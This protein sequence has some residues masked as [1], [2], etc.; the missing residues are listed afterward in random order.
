[1]KIGILTHHYV[2]NF[3]ATLQATA[4][5][6]TIKK[7]NPDAKVE[8][9]NYT[10]KKHKFKNVIRFFR[11]RYDRDTPKSY[12][13]KLKLLNSH[14]KDEKKL[15]RSKKMKSAED[16]NS[17]NYDL[18]IIGSDEVWNF[19][20]IAYS[21]IKFGYGLKKTKVI[22]YAASVGDSSIED[23][24]PK[25]V[26]VGINSLNSISV[27]DKKSLELCF[28]TGHMATKVL[29]PVFIYEFPQINLSENNFDK[30]KKD[31][32]LIYD[33]RITND[34]INEIKK[35]AKKKDLDIIGA[36]EHRKWYSYD[37][38]NVTA[39]EWASL[40]KKAAF[41]ITGTFHGAS[42][43]IK[44]R[45][46]FIVYA[47][48]NNRI[49]KVSSLLQDLNQ[50]ERIITPNS[51]F[52]KLQKLLNTPIDYNQTNEILNHKINESIAYLKNSIKD[53]E[54]IKYV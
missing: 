50:R 49:R 38:T 44:Y 22:T 7:I 2:K 6:E 8:F 30:E 34:Q 19:K 25:E 48:E 29:D 18:I 26:M 52:N 47:T 11:Y 54:N 35:F 46:N 51:D 27:R 14:R 23:E 45:K 20:D 9:I 41:I 24:V 10:I 15:P 17:E 28:D 4:L 13:E 32:I 43:S 33:C 16:I 31:Y 21:P 42:F 3:G 12:V 53:D 5:Y 37:K 40:F 1:M 36:G 39:L